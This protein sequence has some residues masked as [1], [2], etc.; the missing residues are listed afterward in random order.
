MAATKEPRNSTRADRFTFSRRAWRDMAEGEGEAAKAIR[1][2]L[3][4]TDGGDGDPLTVQV[5]RVEG[6][7]EYAPV[8]AAPA[9]PK[10]TR[11]KKA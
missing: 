8:D 6:K 5:R 2:V 10:R 1:S 11:G 7:L 3:G 9:K 4:E